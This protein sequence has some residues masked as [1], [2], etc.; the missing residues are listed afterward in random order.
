[1]R[2]DHVIRRVRPPPFSS[3]GGSADELLDV[4]CGTHERVCVEEIRRRI[5]D[6]MLGRVEVG[7]AGRS[8]ERI[9]HRDLV[10]DDEDRLLGPLDQPPAGARV[11]PAGVVEA[12]AA[13]EWVAPQMVLLP[14]AVRLDRR[15]LE[16]ADVDVVEE[17][18]A[19][20]AR[21]S[22]VRCTGTAG[23]PFTRPSTLRVE[24]A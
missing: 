20:C 24:W 14:G 9:A 2:R 3:S 15:A 18:L 21:P 7:R 4:L 23:S 16:V 12:L 8:V 17:R 22:S 11:P 5:R 19:A 1:M 10:A 6:L 13:G